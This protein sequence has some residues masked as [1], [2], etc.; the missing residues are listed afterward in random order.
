MRTCYQPKNSVFVWSRIAETEREAR[1]DSNYTSL[2][3]MAKKYL[4]LWPHG[5]HSG[6][7]R[8][9][10]EEAHRRNVYEHRIRYPKEPPTPKLD[11]L[12]RKFKANL[13][14]GETKTARTMMDGILAR[15]WATEEQEL[16]EMVRQ[17]PYGTGSGKGQITPCS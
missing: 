6:A 14:I 16:I 2:V 1:N 11:R 13:V 7:D 15:C 8:Q 10:L 17:V 4:K 9:L 3:P 12:C 5:P